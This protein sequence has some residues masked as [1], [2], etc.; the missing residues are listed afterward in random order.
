MGDEKQTGGEKSL[1][2]KLLPLKI[3]WKKFQSEHRL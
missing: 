2:E 1:L 3:T